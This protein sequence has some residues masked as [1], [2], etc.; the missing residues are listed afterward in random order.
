VI[1]CGY[2]SLEGKRETR[3]WKLETRN[4]KSGKWARSRQETGQAGRKQEEKT[5]QIPRYS[6]DDMQG[7]DGGTGAARDAGAESTMI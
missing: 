3:N 6:R 4:W 7:G 5:K 1:N 2:S